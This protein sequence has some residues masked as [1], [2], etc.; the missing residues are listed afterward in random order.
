M[1]NEK[2]NNTGSGKSFRDHQ[3]AIDRALNEKIKSE[4]GEENAG[5][6]T[7]RKERRD[8]ST[9]VSQKKTGGGKQ[10]SPGD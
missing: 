10:K 8:R 7:N 5:A 4:S 2:E 3:R 6:Q 1:E 9:D